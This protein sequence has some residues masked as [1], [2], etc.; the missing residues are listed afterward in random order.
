[1][2]TSF[3]IAARDELM[4]RLQY[5]FFQP[6]YRYFASLWYESRQSLIET[7]QRTPSIE[8]VR[9]K[10]LSRLNR[11]KHWTSTQISEQYLNVT[12]SKEGLF[13]LLLTRTF[14][15]SSRILV[16]AVDIPPA[17]LKISIP[18]NRRFVHAV[19]INAA[20]AFFRNPWLFAHVYNDANPYLQIISLEKTVDAAVL[21]TVRE[22]LNIDN[23]FQPV[24][25][26]PTMVTEPAFTATPSFTNA[27]P[28]PMDQQ[29]Q[30]VDNAVFGQA[31][32]VADVADHN[33][34]EESLSEADDGEGDVRV[35]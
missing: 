22:L 34:N 14:S 26:Q 13:E 1:M 24:T 10:F 18:D 5:M 29:Q 7:G 35:V 27:A 32:D 9:D 6:V 25:T 20:R 11:V 2:E 21:R 15:L 19:F 28:A 8:A 16:F 31:E 3:I 4:S 12:Q 23:I 30:P 33:I 17:F